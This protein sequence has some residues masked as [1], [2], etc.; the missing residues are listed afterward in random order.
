MKFKTKEELI[1][2]TSG[3]SSDN[4]VNKIFYNAGVNDAFN[5]FAERVEFYK[6]YNAKDM[7]SIEDRDNLR[8]EQLD[9]YE[10]K[11]LLE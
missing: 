7:N 8:K 5:S 2:K 10:N 4:D 1:K 9:I 11:E 3:K 6:K